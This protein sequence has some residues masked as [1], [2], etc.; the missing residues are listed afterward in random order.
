MLREI[1]ELLL[2]NPESIIH[3]LDHFGFAN[4]ENRGDEIRCG[5]DGFRNRTS[6]RI[7]LKDN[8]HLYVNDFSGAAS[9]ELFTFIIKS[10]TV[11][12]Q[13]VV[14]HVKSELGLSDGY[15][16]QR[17]EHIF[18]GVFS[19]MH[20]SGSAFA[21][22]RTLDAS[23]LDVYQK[24]FAKRF[25]DDNIPLMAQA[26]FD[27]RY[28]TES[29]RI[30]IPIL[31]VYGE[32][33]GAK[34][35]ANWEIEEDEQ[36]YLYLIPCRCSETLY[37]Y[38]Q[39]YQHMAGETVCVCESEKSVMQAWGYEFQN[40][41]GIGGSRV[42]NQ[43]CKLLVELMP[44]QIILLP[45]VGLSISVTEGNIERL[46]SY[47]R[48]LDIRVGYWDEGKGRDPQKA[49]PTDLGAERLNQILKHEIRWVD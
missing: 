47:T 7:K 11:D 14:K 24:I 28:D 41:V 4:I 5:H 48:M 39:N 43:Q 32:I 9:S 10:K 42:S 29:Q 40:F 38:S 23:V 21:P 33:V 46:K 25:L 13:T 3:T 34:G 36:K 6:I 27:V 18:G 17:R 44:K 2:A 1:K 35:R 19:K 37:G 49:S 12:F 45:D 16:F 20:R 15:D 26:K 8:P 31:D 22:Q 30:V